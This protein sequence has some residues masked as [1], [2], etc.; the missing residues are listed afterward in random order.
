VKR[1]SVQSPNLY[2]VTVTV[3]VSGSV[4][5]SV[6]LTAGVRD[7]RWDANQGLFIN[8]QKIKMR[9]FCDHSNFGG[10]GG[11]RQKATFHTHMLCN[12]CFA[13]TAMEYDLFLL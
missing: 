6:N 3:S 11:E 7:I 13:T 2:T 12:N 4:V 8:E 5:D 10:V 1:W 9:G